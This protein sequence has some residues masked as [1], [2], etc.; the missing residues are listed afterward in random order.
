MLL[1]VGIIS[2][3]GNQHTVDFVL[4]PELITSISELIQFV[5]HLETLESLSSL[6][7]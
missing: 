1:T 7:K 3:S 4:N 2:S 5:E 6:C